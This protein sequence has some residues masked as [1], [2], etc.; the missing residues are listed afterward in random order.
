MHPNFFVELSSAKAKGRFRPVKLVLGLIWRGIRWVY[1]L[2]MYDPFSHIV[3]FNVEVGTPMS[4]FIRGVLYRLAFVP[5]LIAAMACGIVWTATHPRT[6]SMQADP[7]W[8]GVYYEAVTFVGEDKVPIEGW[9]APVLDAKVVL[10]EK[11]NL[12]RKKHPAVVL[13]HDI[14]QRLDQML[15][16]VKPLHDAGFVVLAINC[17]GGGPHATA[18]ETFGIHESED[19]KAAIELLSKRQFVDPSRIAVVGSGTGA[20]AALLA[21]QSD[22]QVAA[23]VAQQ[24]TRDVTDLMESHVMPP[25]HW[26]A[27]MTPLCKWT[28]E[29][30]YNVD[31]EELEMSNF[32]QLMSTNRVLLVDANGTHAD[33]SDGRMIEETTSFLSTLLKSPNAVAEAK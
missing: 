15:P 18:G 27:W 7:V 1:R 32:K 28:F 4:R 23:V 10:V 30:C 20:S 13:V 26:L 33:P 14:G 6:A 5:V 21:A 29:I 31:A 9:L 3:G 2:L 11:E 24:P 25:H 8:L 19:I 17:R 22:P 12:L 16:L